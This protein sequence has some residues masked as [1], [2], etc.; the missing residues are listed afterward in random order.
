MSDWRTVPAEPTDEMLSRGGFHCIRGA[1]AVSEPDK[2]QAKA[3]YTAMIGAAP[4]AWVPIAEAEH[5]KVAQAPVLLWSLDGGMRPSVYEW[6][7]RYQHWWSE[8][9]SFWRA[10]GPSHFCMIPAMPPE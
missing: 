9:G 2:R 10:D 6:S 7:I 8:D 5:V 3:V 1:D 4:S